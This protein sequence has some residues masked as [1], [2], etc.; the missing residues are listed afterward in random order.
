MGRILT[1]PCPMAVRGSSCLDGKQ[2]KTG[3]EKEDEA[4]CSNNH[5]INTEHL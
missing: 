1:S 4:S 2:L 5:F 3:S